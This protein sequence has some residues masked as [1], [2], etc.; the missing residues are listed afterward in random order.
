MTMVKAPSEDIKVVASVP[1]L[2]RDTASV[3]GAAADC[4]GF[5]RAL[6]IVHVGANDIASTFELED[7]ADNSSFADVDVISTGSTIITTSNDETN[8]VWTVDVDLSKIRRYLRV[9]HTA[10]NGTLGTN[11]SAVICLIGSHRGPVSQTVTPL[12]V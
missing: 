9:Q 12:K 2:L 7:S 3:N 5:T 4:L 8:K 10:G 6:V 1:P 11:G